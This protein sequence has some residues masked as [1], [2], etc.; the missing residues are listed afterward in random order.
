MSKKRY[1]K[2]PLLYIQQPNVRTPMARMQSNYRTNRRIV[3]SHTGDKQEEEKIKRA[4][5]QRRPGPRYPVEAPGDVITT[6]TN[7]S[8]K[9]KER[10]QSEKEKERPK[11]KDMSLKQK[12][13]YFAEKPN[14]ISKM[15]CEVKTSN[16][17]FRGIITDFD[18]ET[19]FMRSGRSVKIKTIP[20]SQI[21]RVRMLGL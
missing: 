9:E 21:K 4:R 5:P 8:A 7:E 2:D 20:F 18:G 11:F 14:H 6:D 16:K 13:E 15:K 17:T 12:V 10:E 19:V 1:A 3:T